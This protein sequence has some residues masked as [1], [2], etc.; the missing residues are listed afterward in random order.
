MVYSRIIKYLN[1]KALTD[2][3]VQSSLF[4]S[5]ETDPEKWMIWPKSQPENQESN[6]GLNTQLKFIQEIKEQLIK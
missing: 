4:S 6:L 5:A 1:Q 3:Q 2:L